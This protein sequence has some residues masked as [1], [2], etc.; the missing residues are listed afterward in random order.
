MHAGCVSRDIFN[1]APRPSSMRVSSSNA[2]PRISRNAREGMVLA[3]NV[4]YSRDA[5]ALHFAN[6]HTG[7]T[8]AGNV[9]LGSGPKEGTTPGR[10]LAKDL[11]GLTWDAT[12]TDPRPAPD[13]P[14]PR[15]GASVK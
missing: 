15:A 10:S 5:N 14:F 13:P 1:H 9:V 4:L 12:K 8:I 2:D 11:P 3:D 6:G 7:V